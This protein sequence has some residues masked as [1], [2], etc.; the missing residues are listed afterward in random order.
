MVDYY[1]V[2][3]RAVTAPDAGD[4]QWRSE[5]Y[6]RAR[7]ML[8]T[9]LRALRPPAPQAEIAAEEAALD[10][11]IARIESELAWTDRG[12]DISEVG[13]AKP[14]RGP[15]ANPIQL[16]GTTWIVLAIVIAALGAGGFV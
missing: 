14:A 12:G 6:D 8:D 13:A 10:A 3:L 15:I 5:V 7:Q 2:L 4:Q 16:S 1:S 9:R 11:A